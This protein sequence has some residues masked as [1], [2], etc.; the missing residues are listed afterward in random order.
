MNTLGRHLSS[1]TKHV[2]ESWITWVVVGAAATTAVLS[3]SVFLPSENMQAT[4]P[5]GSE[6]EA[7]V[8]EAE[9]QANAARNMQGAS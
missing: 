8:A 4:A 3:S 2:L 9:A 7:A 5:S 1:A 6:I